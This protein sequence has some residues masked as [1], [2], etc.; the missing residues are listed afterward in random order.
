MP[1]Y[2][3]AYRE[4][5]STETTICQEIIDLTTM[6]DNGKSDILVMLD[7]IAAFDTVDH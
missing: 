1:M 5:H 2:Q 6:L 3:S 4:N 7:L